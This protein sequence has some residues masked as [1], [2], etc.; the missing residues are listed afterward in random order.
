M[1]EPNVDHHTYQS[2][3]MATLRSQAE[4]AV[5]VAFS[6]RHTP[7]LTGFLSKGR[8]KPRFPVAFSGSATTARSVP[9]W[10][11]L[12]FGLAICFFI[13]HVIQK[14]GI[15]Q[16]ILDVQ[17]AAFLINAFRGYSCMRPNAAG[18]HPHIAH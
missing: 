6:H 3:S 11:S 15:A 17:Q 12:R 13:D 8:D 10:S 7:L 16:H 14:S 1:R 9:L 4:S 2:V 18:L 5:R